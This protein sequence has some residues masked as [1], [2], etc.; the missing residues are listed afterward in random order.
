MC[1]CAFNTVQHGVQVAIIDALKKHSDLLEGAT[2]YSTLCPDNKDSQMI[3][4]VG[5]TRVVYLNDT[6]AKYVFS[7]AAKR[8]LEGLDCR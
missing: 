5:I 7:V 4:E 2:L 1:L 8:I 3:R 6:Y